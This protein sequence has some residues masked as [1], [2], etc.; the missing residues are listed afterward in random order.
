MDLADG[1]IAALQKLFTTENIGDWSNFNIY[2]YEI[3]LLS[4]AGSFSSASQVSKSIYRVS[5]FGIGVF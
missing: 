1:H 5:L 2:L 3:Y 4:P